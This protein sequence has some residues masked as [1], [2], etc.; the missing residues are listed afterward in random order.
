M[1]GGGEDGRRSEQVPQGGDEFFIFFT[2]G[3]EEIKDEKSLPK[4]AGACYEDG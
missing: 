4:K 1:I 2:Q 3:V